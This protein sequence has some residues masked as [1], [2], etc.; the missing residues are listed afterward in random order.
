MRPSRIEAARKSHW[1]C[2]AD[3]PPF[4]G[5]GESLA[6]TANGSTTN[7]VL[8]E[9][10]QPDSLKRAYALNGQAVTAEEK[11]IAEARGEDGGDQRALRCE[12][13]RFRSWSR[14]GHARARNPE[15][16][17]LLIALSRA[18]SSGP[19]RAVRAARA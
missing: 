17:I 4:A 16:D 1:R 15:A 18:A 2:G 8:Q 12:Q 19:A 3:H 7:R 14:R 5:A 6:R 10:E 13:K 9:R 11:I